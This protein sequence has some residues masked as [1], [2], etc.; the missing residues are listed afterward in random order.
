MNSPIL[1]LALVTQQVEDLAPVTP[2]MLKLESLLQQEF[3]LFAS[4]IS[5]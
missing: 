3:G 2:L 4:E 1:I 5:S